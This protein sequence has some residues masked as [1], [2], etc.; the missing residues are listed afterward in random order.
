[1]LAHCMRNTNCIVTSLPICWRSIAISVFVCL[2]VCLSA[3][4]SENRVTNF[5]QN[6][7]HMLPLA[8]QHVMYFR[9]VDDVVFSH[10]GNN[11]P[12]SNTTL[13]FVSSPGGGNGGEVCH[14]GLHILSLW[15]SVTRNWL[16]YNCMKVDK[17]LRHWLYSRQGCIAAATSKIRGTM[18]VLSQD[19][20]G[21]RRQV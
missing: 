19:T 1:M 10:D 2:F 5:R 3:R 20:R 16:Q 7:L 9:F 17:E 6:F 12:K 21:G 13:Y 8:V 18:A 11:R 4:I 14:F 15:C